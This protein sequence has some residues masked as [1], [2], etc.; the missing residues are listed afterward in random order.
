MARNVSN[1][2]FRDRGSGR[3]DSCH[4]TPEGRSLPRRDT[5][6]ATRGMLA[7]RPRNSST[8]NVSFSHGVS[9]LSIA[10]T[11]L[12]LALVHFGGSLFRAQRAQLVPFGYGS[13]P[14]QN[15]SLTVHQ[16]GQT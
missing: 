6:S 10:R 8:S 12:D 5:M 3:I 7:M 4:I 2:A 16:H 9:A 13:C 14:P 11:V 1:A 15:F